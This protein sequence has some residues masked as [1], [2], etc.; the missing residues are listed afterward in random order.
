MGPFYD[1]DWGNGLY[2]LYTCRQLVFWYHVD[3]IINQLSRKSLGPLSTERTDALPQDP[4]KSWSPEIWCY[5]DVITRIIG[6]HLGSA[7]A[8]Q[9]SKRLEKSKSESRDTRS[10]GKTSVRLVN[11]GLDPDQSRDNHT[12]GVTQPSSYHRYRCSLTWL[13][14]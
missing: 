9:M 10:Y 1:I 14:P 8:C 2:V 6:R 13:A 12:S 4:V 5:N 3:P 7:A 11:R